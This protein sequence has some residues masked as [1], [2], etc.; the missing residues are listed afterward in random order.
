[1]KQAGSI[2]VVMSEVNVLRLYLVK[3][4]VEEAREQKKRS[5]KG[6]KR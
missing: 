2:K 1:M 3:M 6:P 5:F 4:V